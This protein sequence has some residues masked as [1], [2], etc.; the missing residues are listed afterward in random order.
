MLLSSEILNFLLFFQI[1]PLLL[2]E[3][4]DN[5]SLSLYV[6]T[7]REHC[8]VRVCKIV[9]HTVKYVQ[10]LQYS[11]T[12]QVQ[13]PCSTLYNVLHVTRP[14][15]LLPTLSL[16]VQYVNYQNHVF[17]CGTLLDFCVVYLPYSTSS[18]QVLK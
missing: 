11:T 3:K 5:E 6:R 18:V 9:L 7:T 13:K 8:S 2:W 4:R 1:V 15:C 17:Y 10:Y 16:L 12:I 14:M